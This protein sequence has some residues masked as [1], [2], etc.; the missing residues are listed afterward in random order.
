MT[1]APRPQLR[2][3]KHA[4]GVFDQQSVDLALAYALPF[5]PA[6]GQW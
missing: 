6:G 1:R 4:P 2:E 3:R 5:I